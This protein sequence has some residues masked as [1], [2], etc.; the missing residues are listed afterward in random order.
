MGSLRKNTHEINIFFYALSFTNVS[1]VNV[2]LSLEEGLCETDIELCAT[3]GSIAFSNPF[4]KDIF[5]SNSVLTPFFDVFHVG[6]VELLLEQPS[7]RCICYVTVISHRC[8][9]ESENSSG[10]SKKG[11]SLVRHLLCVRKDAFYE[12]YR[13]EKKNDEFRF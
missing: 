12:S 1:S 13:E 5:F 7:T 4:F 3:D 2:S 9:I 6:C 8:H 10:T 11:S